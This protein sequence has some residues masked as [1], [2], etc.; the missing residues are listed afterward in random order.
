VKA[1][2]IDISSE[3][4]SAGISEISPHIRQAGAQ[5]ELKTSGRQLRDSYS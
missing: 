3:L 2:Q 4:K 1:I 5:P